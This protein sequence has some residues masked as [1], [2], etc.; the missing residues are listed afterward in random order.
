MRL[1]FFHDETEKKNRK[2]RSESRMEKSFEKIICWLL[3]LA[4]TGSPAMQQ[5]SL[6]AE[7]SAEQEN[8]VTDTDTVQNDSIDL[9]LVEGTDHSTDTG[10]G[11]PD[12]LLEDPGIIEVPQN[13]GSEI[14][15][16][17]EEV[18]DDGS[19]I[20]DED[21]SDPGN[22][23]EAGASA[24]NDFSGAGDLSDGDNGETERAEV[25]DEEN[26]SLIHI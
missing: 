21:V 14:E 19:L 18:G 4:L 8:F 2:N 12:S 6:A 3:C 5:V 7:N 25:S 16:W 9:E 11:T 15:V 17:S 13:E 20:E 1:K 23:I 26:L 24:G 22:T 10:S